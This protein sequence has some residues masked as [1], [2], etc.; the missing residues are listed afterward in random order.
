MNTPVEAGVAGWSGEGRLLSGAAGAAGSG[1]EGTCGAAT[2]A[3]CAAT[4]SNRSGDGV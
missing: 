3:G 2:G 4:P 1:T